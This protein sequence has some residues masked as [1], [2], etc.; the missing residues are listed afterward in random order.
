MNEIDIQKVIDYIES[1]ICDE[2]DLNDLTKITLSSGSDLQRTFKMVVGLTINEYIHHRRLTLAAIDLKKGQSRIID[3]A[4][5]YGY[6]TN[7]SFSK[8]FKAFH[9]CLPRVAKNTNQAIQY[10]YPIT[11]KL[12]KKGGQK[13]KLEDMHQENQTT[14]SDYY[15]QSNEDNRLKKKNSHQVEFLSTMYVFRQLFHKPLK[16]LDCCAGGGIY[17]FEL[18]KKHEVVAGDLVEKH[19]SLLKKKQ[20][21]NPL[22]KDI[23]QINVLDMS[24]FN[25]E[26]FDVV[27]C[28][29]AL[30]HLQNEEDRQKAVNECIRVVKKGGYIV[31]SY[32][33]RWGN[34]MNGLANHLKDLDLLYQ[35]WNSGN[36]E[37][38][39]YRMTSC[40]MDDLMKDKNIT[41]I[42]NIGVDH[43]AY[44]ASEQINMLNQNDFQRFMNYQYQAMDDPSI[45][46]C[47]LHGLWIGQK[48]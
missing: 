21:S 23:V 22:L 17:A 6:Q 48:N 7:E 13:V 45:R 24:I 32:L 33:N 18:A 10:F 29:G 3:I 46:S 11:I 30:Y 5:R 25:D 40:E 43:F 44:L 8:A 41:C 4:L 34:F 31:F 19:V 20:K 16:I 38:I 28:M 36:H 15:N 2:I 39:F 37:S 12:A 27:L 1:H 47:A 9:G 35:E 26:S 14:L 42:K